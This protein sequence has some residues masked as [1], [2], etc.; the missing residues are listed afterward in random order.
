MVLLDG[1]EQLYK[2][3][4]KYFSLLDFFLTFPSRMESMIFTDISV[5]AKKHKKFS[6]LPDGDYI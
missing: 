2:A 4:T 3:F 5:I 1:S 6:P